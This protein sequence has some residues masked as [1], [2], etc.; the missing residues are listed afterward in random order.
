[1]SLGV[2]LPWG[3]FEVMCAVKGGWLEEGGRVQEVPFNDEICCEGSRKRGHV[4]LTML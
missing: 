4:S 3:E 1:M 2:L